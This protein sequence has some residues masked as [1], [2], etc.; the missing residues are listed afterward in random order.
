MDGS[1]FFNRSNL[2][3]SQWFGEKEALKSHRSGS[4]SLGHTAKELV[5]CSGVR[6]WFG[7][8]IQP[9]PAGQLFVIAPIKSAWGRSA[10]NAWM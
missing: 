9:S 1:L 10:M 5:A 4:Q 3:L 8:M 2:C 7:P 6:T